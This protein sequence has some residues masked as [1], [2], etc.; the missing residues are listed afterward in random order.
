MGFE[1]GHAQVEMQQ[2]SLYSLD[3]DRDVRKQISG[4]NISNGLA[5]TDDNR[6][7][8]YTESFPKKIYA[9]DFDL[10]KGEISE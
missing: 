10:E 7:F 3:T 4:V 5:W 9:Y 1:T 6:T 8:F 2:G